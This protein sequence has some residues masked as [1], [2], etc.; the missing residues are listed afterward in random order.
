MVL[1]TVIA[2]RPSQQKMQILCQLNPENAVQH[3]LNIPQIN[4]CLQ[5]ADTMFSHLLLML[6]FSLKNL[7]GSTDYRIVL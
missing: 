4:P 2:R 6:I 7:T 3:L 5:P 1:K